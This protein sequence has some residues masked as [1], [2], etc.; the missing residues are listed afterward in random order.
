[1]D[2]KKEDISGIFRSCSLPCICMILFNCYN[3]A[4]NSSAFLYKLNM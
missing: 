4:T 3:P 1:M 2:G